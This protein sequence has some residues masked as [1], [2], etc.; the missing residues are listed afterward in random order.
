[1]AVQ[2]KTLMTGNVKFLAPAY[3]DIVIQARGMGQNIIDTKFNIKYICQVIINGQT[4]ATLKA[5]VDPALNNRALFRIQSILQDYTE[6]DKLGFESKFQVFDSTFNGQFFV[7][8][9]HSIH[10]IDKFARNKNNLNAVFCLGGREYSNTID[11]ELIQ[12]L[13]IDTEASFLFFNSVI[14]HFDGFSS[15]DFS[16]Y[17]LNA[18]NKKFLSIF[19]SAFFIGAETRGQKIQ[20]NQYHTVA[21]LN[22][23]HYEDSEVTRIR[24][25][26]Y[27]SSDTIIATQFVDNTN[28]NGGAAFGTSIEYNIFTDVGNTDEGLLYFGCG[29]AQLELLGFDMTNV[30]SYFVKAFNDSDAPLTSA[31]NA[32]KFEI[33]PADCKGFETI[34]LAFLNRLGA[35]DYYNFTKKSTRTTQIQKSPIKQNYGITTQHSTTFGGLLLDKPQYSQDVSDGGTRTFN[36]NAIQTIEA[37]TDFITEQEAELLEELFTS[38][39]VYMQ[40]GS[41]FEPV[42]INETEYIKQTTA[43]DML[44]QYIIT[45]EKA[46]NTRV[47]RL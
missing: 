6:T 28:A 34:R 35:Y 14:Q 5:P 37:N 44:K 9:P 8:A 25:Q 42:V 17:L 45:I 43:N 16:S 18:A 26:T 19:P 12:E 29:T 7:D 27:D 36:V 13:S 39:D 10:Q 30:A 32:Y 47:Q 46:H 2:L 24:I 4:V 33:Q 31:S 40:T 1:M 22:G 15:Q 20:L 21:F 3:S 38:P 11:G 23:K 41:T